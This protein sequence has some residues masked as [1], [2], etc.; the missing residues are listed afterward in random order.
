VGDVVQALVADGKDVVHDPAT[1]LPGLQG[2]QRGGRGVGRPRLALW[3]RGGGAAAVVLGCCVM[4]SSLN[5]GQH[6]WLLRHAIS[7]DVGQH[8]GQ[9][10]FARGQHTHPVVGNDRVVDVQQLVTFP[11]EAAPGAAA[12]HNRPCMTRR[13]RRRVVD[14]SACATRQHPAPSKGPAPRMQQQP[15]APG[16]A[17]SANTQLHPPKAQL[18]SSWLPSMPTVVR[19]V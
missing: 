12:T 16:S 6:A 3:M 2:R 1:L 18:R 8:A 17:G 9:H 13:R 15:G 5:V 14:T 11:L 4:P 10:C 7:P 19:H